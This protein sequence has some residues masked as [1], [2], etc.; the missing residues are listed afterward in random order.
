MNSLPTVPTFTELGVPGME[1]SN[2]FGFFAP[3]ATPPDIVTRLHRELETIMRAPDVV[4]R[5]DKLGA[6]PAGGTPEQFA[7]L[8]RAEYESWKAVI[9]RAGIKAE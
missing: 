5:L 2:W 3:P 6:E 9:Q 7:R 8:Y 4:E 1:F